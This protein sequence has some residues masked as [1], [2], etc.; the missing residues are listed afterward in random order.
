MALDL[1]TTALVKA[2][3]GIT[4]STEDT[5][6]DTIVTAVSQEIGIYCQR[7]F[8][9]DLYIEQ[10]IGNGENEIVL[11]NCP[12]DSV[13]FAGA[14][15]STA[16]TVTYTGTGLGNVDIQNQKVVLSDNLSTTDVDIAETHTFTNL[17]SSIDGV[18]NFSATAETTTAGWPALTMIQKRYT[19]LEANETQSIGAALS[20]LPLTKVQ[21]G[22]YETPGNMSQGSPFIVIYQG[23]YEVGSVPAGLEQLA[24]KIAADVYR[25]ISQDSN[26]KSEKIS[27]Y[28]WTA[29]T[30]NGAIVDAINA[31]SQRLDFY[32]NK[33]L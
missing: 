3:L 12:I 11:P 14:G 22:L 29:N 33:R 27:K 20:E 32:A 10:L 23:G 24:T 6:I 30:M 18:S 19:S 16:L 2:Y 17:A 26:L 25:N 4:G 1:T 8:S 13:M 7:E 5:K 9:M 15:N 21:D 28:S 31:S